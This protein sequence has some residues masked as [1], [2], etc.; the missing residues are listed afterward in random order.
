M[1]WTRYAFPEVVLSDREIRDDTDIERRLNL[2]LL[3]GLRSDVEIY[4]CQG[5]VSMTPMYQAYL[6]KINALRK[7]Y[8]VLMA[9]YRDTVGLSNSDPANLNARLFTDGAETAV[10]AT[11][12]GGR[13][14]GGVVSVPGKTFVRSDGI[15]GARVAADGNGARVDLDA[16]ALAVLLFK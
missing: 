2:N 1:D 5:L 11:T 3:V 14:G 4:R 7:R 12:F 8:P 13:A 10:V 6:G 15:G 9:T 16:N